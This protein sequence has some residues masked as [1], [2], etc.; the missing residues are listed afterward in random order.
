MLNIRLSMKKKQKLLNRIDPMRLVSK[1][2]IQRPSRS[3]HKGE[4][5]IKGC[6]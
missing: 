5:E 6:I 3:F 4:R 2:G 1:C